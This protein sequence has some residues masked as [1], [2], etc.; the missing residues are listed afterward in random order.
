MGMSSK[1]GRQGLHLMLSW[2]GLCHLRKE[3]PYGYQ[4]PV[5]HDPLRNQKWR[6]GVIR[7]F[8]EVTPNVSKTFRCFGISRTAYYRWLERYQE[9]EE[10]GLLDRS[11]RPIYSPRATQHEVLAKI[12]YLRQTYHFGPWKIKVYLERYHDIHVSSSGIWRILK[13]LQMNRLP[14]NQQ[15]KRHQERWKRYEKPQP[16]RGFRSMLGS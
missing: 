8:E 4:L 13:K 11:R 1:T 12:I 14:I 9:N 2:L 6:L 15:Y 10:E 5:N 16:G 7:H 3:K